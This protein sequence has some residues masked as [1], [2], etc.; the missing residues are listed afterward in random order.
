MNRRFLIAVLCLAGATAAQAVVCEANGGPSNLPATNPDAAYTV[1]G[2]GTVTDTRTGLMWK[3]CLEGQSGPACAGS[4]TGF[5]W[6]AALAQAAASGFAGH[7]DWRVPN[8]KELRSLV[9]EC[10]QQPA[11]NDAV[12]SNTP[13]LDSYAWSSSPRAGAPD[14]SLLVNF[15]TGS[16]TFGVRTAAVPV[17]LVRAGPP[18]APPGGGGSSSAPVAVPTLAHGGVLLLSAVLALL[19]AASQIGL[20]RLRSKR[21]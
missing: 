15:S 21:R 3:Q 13:A 12:F 16:A 5:D 6:G 4:P 20:R 9:E 2:D 17:R 19:S 18:V 11:I 1:H 10:R 7:T 8:Q 14:Y